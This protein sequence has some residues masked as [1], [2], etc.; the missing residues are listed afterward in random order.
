MKKNF[1]GESEG[2]GKDH[3]HS[4]K[5]LITGGGGRKAASGIAL[6]GDPQPDP[7]AERSYRQLKAKAHFPPLLSHL[8][9][10]TGQ[11]LGGSG[12]RRGSLQPSGQGKPGDGTKR[13]AA[14]GAFAPAAAGV[15]PRCASLIVTKTS[16]ETKAQARR[17]SA[18]HP[19]APGKAPQLPS[20]RC[21][22][23]VTTTKNLQ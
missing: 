15:S 13:G 7:A 23:T 6:S 2:P 8:P 22:P 1:K 12:A 19:T 11:A 3:H 20:P 17:H 9:V 18:A 16:Y 5:V 21:T 14:G 4:G 10:Q